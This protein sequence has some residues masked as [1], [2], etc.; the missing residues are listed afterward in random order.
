M[1]VL[2]ALPEHLYPADAFAGFDPGRGA[3]PDNARA[4]AW[5]AQ[6]AYESDDPDKARRLCDRWGFELAAAVSAASDGLLPAASTRALVARRH[7]VAWLAFQGTDPLV[8]ANWIT[9]LD[10]RRGADG[11]ARGFRQALD[12]AW[13]EIAAILGRAAIAG[14]PL[15]VSG[16]SLGGSLAVLAALRLATEPAA[17]GRPAAVFTFGM[18]RTGDA[19]FAA[20]YDAC[21]LTG[22]TL[23]LVYGRDV[24]PAVPPSELGFRHVGRRWSCPRGE[25]FDPAA[26]AEAPDDEPHLATLLPAA[27]RRLLQEPGPAGPHVGPARTD[28]AGR[29]IDALP[30]ELRDHIPDRYWTA[31][32][33][34]A[35]APGP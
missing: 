32:A 33:R 22:R 15:F 29:I 12:V 16:H 19:G 5:A 21:G 7:D 30:G 9:D 26:I 3:A 14:R 1:S 23:R 4:M 10:A 13:P 24:V 31:L 17:G 27:L 18:P 8:A 28:A 11:V 34:P 6:A 2:V 25:R 35:A 20:R